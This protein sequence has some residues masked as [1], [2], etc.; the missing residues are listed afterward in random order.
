MTDAHRPLSDR[1]KKLGTVAC[2]YK[3]VAKRNRN[4]PPPL[5]HEHAEGRREGRARGGEGREE[6]RSKES[7]LSGYQVIQVGEMA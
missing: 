4:F 1:L 2:R 6:Q 7:R 3:V 5:N